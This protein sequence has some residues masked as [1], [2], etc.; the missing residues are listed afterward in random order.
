MDDSSL[1]GQF[2]VEIL[3]VSADF[4]FVGTIV[5][6]DDHSSKTICVRDNCH[7]TYIDYSSRRYKWVTSGNAAAEFKDKLELIGPSRANTADSGFDITVYMLGTKKKASQ[8]CK[9]SCNTDDNYDEDDDNSLC[10]K[11]QTHTMKTNRGHLYVTYSV[12]PDA[13]QGF[14]EVLLQLPS[15][16]RGVAGATIYGLITSRIEMFDIGSTLFRKDLN[17]SVALEASPHDASC[18]KEGYICMKVPLMRYVLAVP[19]RKYLHIEGKLQVS[20]YDA[21]PITIDHRI[22]IDCENVHT[23]WIKRGESLSAVRMWLRSIF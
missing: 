12:L 22:P 18:S 8:M 23:P 15:H 11:L 17:E 9:L 2:L 6:C 16:W 14:V 1:I 20:G 7:Q 19:V 10:N 21:M 5:V 3:D 13:M 4:P